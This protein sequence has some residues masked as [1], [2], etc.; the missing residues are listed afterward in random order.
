MLRDTVKRV[1]YRSGLLRAMHQFRNTRALTAV[2]F[3][4]VLPAADPRLPHA[5]PGYVVT[6]AEFEQCLDFFARHYAIVSLEAVFDWWTTGAPLP[7]CP[8]LITF[9]DGWADNL[10]VAAP[11]LARRRMPAV[12]FT[13]TDPL[14]EPDEIWWQDVIVH[15]VRTGRIYGPDMRPF[16]ASLRLAGKFARTDG[17]P[18]EKDGLIFELLRGAFQMNPSFR[19]ELLGP[20]MAHGHFAPPRQMLRPE[21]LS[22]LASTGIAVAAHGASHLPLTMIDKPEDDLRRCAGRLAALRPDQ[23]PPERQSLSLPHG[24][25]DDAVLRIA[26]AAG[27]AAVFSSEPVLNG[28]D[29]GRSGAIGRIYVARH[30]FLDADGAFVPE[31]LANWLMRRPIRL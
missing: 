2:M 1:A 25:F 17:P 23:T 4:R 20:A 13:A 10:H 8:L 26:H 24:R 18:P 14:D 30:A 29:A 16:M 22:Q 21:E 9:D 19:R 11:L 7:A 31:R 3:H 15:A 28:L 27:F 6:D 12:V 5:E